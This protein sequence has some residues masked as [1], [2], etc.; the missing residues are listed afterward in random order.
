MFVYTVFFVL[1][2]FFVEYSIKLANEDGSN[3]FD[4]NGSNQGTTIASM[5]ETTKSPAN[6]ES[7]SKKI[8]KIHLDL[9]GL[10]LPLTRPRV[11]IEHDNVPEPSTL[12]DTDPKEVSRGTIV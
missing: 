1:T 5:S 8:K 2:K 7:S 12:R 10:T 9:V 11:V 3:G 6:I 4:D